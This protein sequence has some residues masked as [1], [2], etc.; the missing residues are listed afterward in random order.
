M[1]GATAAA[2]STAA[3]S[4]GGL[5]VVAADVTAIPERVHHPSAMQGSGPYWPGGVAAEEPMT[6]RA[7]L[8]AIQAQRRLADIRA[9]REAKRRQLVLIEAA[10]PKW[11][12]PLPPARTGSVPP[13]VRAGAP[14]TR[15]WTW[16]PRPA[17]RSTQ[18]ATAPCW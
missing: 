10:R 18:P 6:G 15:A 8:S 4:A 14:A 5:D 3:A 9:T 16:P 13:T 7:A 11:K 17:R 2:L 1:V 12:L